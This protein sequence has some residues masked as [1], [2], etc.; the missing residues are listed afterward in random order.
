MLSIT[1][2]GDSSP[3]QSS[4]TIRAIRSKA[5]SPKSFTL[6]TLLSKNAA[7]AFL[8]SVRLKSSIQTISQPKMK[9][10]G[11]EPSR[12]SSRHSLDCR[13]CAR[14]DE[15]SLESLRNDDG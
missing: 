13:A 12:L 14:N 11:N 7:V 5:H 1:K 9:D 2:R 10:L 4:Q 8:D 6:S 3:K 15:R